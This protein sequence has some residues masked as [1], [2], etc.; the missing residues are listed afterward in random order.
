MTAKLY[1][2]QEINEY[3]HIQDA[4]GASI[5]CMSI[6]RNLITKT[7]LRDMSLGFY[8]VVLIV[9]GRQVYRIDKE[10]VSLEMHDIMLLPPHRHVTFLDSTQEVNS[11]HIF[12]DTQYYEDVL[13]FDANL[14]SQLPLSVIGSHSVFHLDETKAAEFYDLFC[15]IQKAIKHP[16]LYKG[17]MLRH[18]VHVLQLYLAEM[19]HGDHMMTHTHD[20]KHKEN[21][22][23]LFIHLATRNFRKERQIKFYADQLNITP[24]Y[25]SRTVK[26][27]SGNTVYGYLSSFLYNEICN[28]LKTTDMTMSE[29]ADELNFNDQSALTNFFKAKSRTTPLAYRNNKQRKP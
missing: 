19:I 1:N 28:L 18:L 8:S 9:D 14:S 15:Q 24:T 11:V 29:I 20:I 26:D 12:L 13:R 6:D 25:L 10:E 7:P 5:S 16:H 27:L 4:F 2:L 23:K 3:Y 21:L 17:E 22:F